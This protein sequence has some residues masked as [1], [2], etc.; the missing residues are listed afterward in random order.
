MDIG[1]GVLFFLGGIICIFIAVILFFAPLIIISRLEK[2]IK[3]LQEAEENKYEQHRELMALL[4][5]QE[6]NKESQEPQENKEF[7]KDRRAN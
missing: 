2:I 6:K 7:D 1:I 3:L 5:E 4:I